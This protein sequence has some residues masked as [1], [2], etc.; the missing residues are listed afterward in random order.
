MRPNQTKFLE[1]I[2]PR[3][4]WLNSKR[5]D[6]PT[7]GSVFLE[8]VMASIQCRARLSPFCG[9]GRLCTLVPVLESLPLETVCN[10]APGTY[11]R[12][13][14]VAGLWEDT[15]RL[16]QVAFALLTDLF[17]VMKVVGRFLSHW[18]VA[19]GWGQPVFTYPP[20]QSNLHLIT[21]PFPGTLGWFP[22]P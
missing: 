17:L 7:L 4:D 3:C 13:Q 19:G 11:G 20:Q 21:S 8:K 6:C 9:K 5:C 14:G 22:F 12:A 1:V 18:E 10:G 2:S 16:G 15:S